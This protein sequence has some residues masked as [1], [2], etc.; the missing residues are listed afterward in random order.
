MNKLSQFLAFPKDQYWLACK[1]LL[2]YLKGTIGLGLIF[3]PSSS[4]MP[5]HVYTNADHVSCKV[6]KL[7]TSGLHVFLTNN[8]IVWSSKKQTI[9]ARSMGEAKYCVVARGVAEILWLKSLF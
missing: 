9:V 3:T 8:L 5:L 7:F 1:R 6:T 4:D 2:Q